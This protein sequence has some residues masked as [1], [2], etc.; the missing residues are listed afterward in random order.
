M[1]LQLPLF[2]LALAALLTACSS[3]DTPES[4][5]ATQPAG[6]QSAGSTSSA[7]A[8]A[9]PA[10]TATTAATKRLG[11]PG[12]VTYSAN[13]PATFDPLPGAKTSTGMLGSAVYRIEI[14][15]DW[16]GDLVLF[17]H[18]YRGE[19]KTLTVGNPP[20]ALRELLIEQG[21][22]WA[23]SS[24]SENSYA[25]GIGADDTLALKQLFEKEHGE[26][27]RTLLYGES[28]G[29]NVIA[30]SL[31]HYPEEYDGALSVCGAIGGQEQLDFLAS[32]AM[33][34]EYFSGMPIDIGGGPAV[35]NTTT[36]LQM[37]GT[38]GSPE[39]PSARGE[40]FI[41]AVRM[42]T[43][44]P[45]P[46]YL[47]G[48]DDQYIA[49]FA[50]LLIDPSRVTPMTLAATNAGAVYAI[51]PGLGVT[52]ETL[53]TAVR[54]LAADPKYR[55]ASAYPDRVPTTAKISDPLLTL[56][57]TGDLFV[58]I[59]QEVD[60]RKKAEAAGTANLLVQR[61]IRAGGHCQFSAEEL[62]TAWND[63]VTWVNDG[64]KPAGDNLAGDL[65]DIGT[66]FT[67]PLRPGDPGVK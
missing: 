65:S 19:T 13:P 8:D 67:N 61:A 17:A 50:F 62:T 60:Y 43:G 63:L 28:M 38:L 26:A 25:P 11:V 45:R 4:P 57:N 20:R 34:G 49:N 32:W 40:Q 52:N 7:T 51:E 27:N 41:S 46:F 37:A 21:Y 66:Q 47:E 64:K 33:L 59:S 42:L 2:A 54:R 12:N 15:D 9:S 36:L 44:G 58:P 23:A 10:V 30:L 1:R 56:H 31:E 5:S 14:P 35:L 48:F 3:K 39:A 16:N 6:T 22:A 24:Y 55:D 29:G 18:G 53:N